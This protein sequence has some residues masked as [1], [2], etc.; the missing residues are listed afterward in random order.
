VCPCVLEV[1]HNK[2]GIAS[3][4]WLVAW[5]EATITLLATLQYERGY[6]AIGCDGSS[7]KVNVIAVDDDR[8]TGCALS[9]GL[10]AE[11]AYLLCEEEI[12]ICHIS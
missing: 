11:V 4:V 7:V 5:L 1:T 6:T 9:Q 3:A 10:V 12:T 2:R 8:F